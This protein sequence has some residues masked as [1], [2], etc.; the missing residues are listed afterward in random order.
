[1]LFLEI[2]FNAIF[3][4]SR[5]CRPSGRRDSQNHFVIKAHQFSRHSDAQFFKTLRQRV[6]DYFTSSNKSKFGGGRLIFKMGVMLALF[7]VPFFTLLFGGISSPWLFIGLW[8]LMGLGIAGIGVNIMHDANHGSFSKNKFINNSVRLVMNL[9]G[10]DAS[11]WRL[12]HNVLHHTYT[13]I[14]ESDEDIIGPPFLRFSPHDEKKKVH[15]LQFIYAWFLYGMMTLIKV[16]YTD[17]KRAIRYRKMGLIRTR[18]EF[19]ARLF[20]ISI[21]KIMYFAYMLVLPMILTS[22][23][24]LVIAGFL[25]MH[26]VSGF[27]LTVIFQT[28][29]VMPTTE[30]PLPNEDGVMDNSWAVHQLRTTT[31]FAP[32]SRIF[33][34]FVGGLNYQ[35]EHHLFANISHVHYR[36]LSKIVARTARE[37]G[38]PY[39]SQPTFAMAVASHGRMLYQLGR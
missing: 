17:F 4:A 29:H 25:V 33:S 38:I 39:H 16:A 31:N 15:R 36:D 37:F 27:V 30:Y 5:P 2:F 9:L 21:G 12:Q 11:I 24:W 32:K 14:H 22:N 3:Y 28:A 13:N 1:M 18:K 20:K 7:F 23:I 19:V 34:W 10:G 6:N 35:V 26:L 8:M